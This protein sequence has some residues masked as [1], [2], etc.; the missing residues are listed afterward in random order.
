MVRPPKATDVPPQFREAVEPFETKTVTSLG[1]QSPL[2]GGAAL[3]LSNLKPIKNELRVE[4]RR[5][6]VRTDI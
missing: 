1:G 6:K 2:P 3:P 5:P 4:I